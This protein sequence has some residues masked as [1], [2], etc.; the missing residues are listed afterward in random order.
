M[1]TKLTNVIEKLENGE[2][3]GGKSVR[4]TLDGLPPGRYLIEVSKYRKD[5]S[6]KQ[7]RF[8]F[9]NFMQS[10]MDCFKERWGY[11]YNKDQIHNWN[12]ANFWSDERINNET[13]EVI[14]MPASSSDN[15]TVE[16][17]EKMDIMRSWFMEHMDWPLPFP[18]QQ[19]EIF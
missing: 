18:L 11:S 10:Q 7:N 19:Q 4:A 12:K 9:G 1:A 16:W 13:G 17:E 15:T 2:L 6:N 5:R 8:Y 3:K 14:K